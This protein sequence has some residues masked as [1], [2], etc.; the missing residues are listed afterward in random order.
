MQADAADETMNE[1][2]SE[3]GSNVADYYD[4]FD[5]YDHFSNYCME[6]KSE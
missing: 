4:L 5:Y 3:F 2:S 6:V 1:L